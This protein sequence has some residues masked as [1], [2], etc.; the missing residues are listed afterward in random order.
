ML[1]CLSIDIKAQKDESLTDFK[2]FRCG[3]YGTLGPSWMKPDMKDWKNEGMR[4]GYG[5]GFMAEF[6]VAPNLVIAS[7]FDVMYGSGK[8]KL[9]DTLFSYDNMTDKLSNINSIYKIQYL[10]IPITLKMRTNEINYFRYYMRVGGS[11]GLR[12]G[13][14]YTEEISAQDNSFIFRT[15][16]NEKANNRISLFRATFD[17]GAGIEYSLGGTTALLG[18]IYFNNGLTN[19]LKEYKNIKYKSILNYLMFKIGILF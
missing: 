1:F 11:L 9:S 10:Q 12:I 17:I 3:M 15:Y 8:M 7:G 18:E 19:S 2:F 6:A 13:T 5:F 16:D 14:K 4:F